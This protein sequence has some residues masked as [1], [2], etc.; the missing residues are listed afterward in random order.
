MA[1][2]DKKTPV[3][4][5]EPSSSEM[6][7]RFKA[8]PA[9]FIGTIIVLVLVVV[10]FVL[11]PALVPESRRG[12]GDL[13]FGY[14][15]KVP[16]SWV[17]G[18][19]F[20]QYQERIARYYQSTMDP[21]QLQYAG[22]NIWRQAFEGA[23]IHTAILQE[24][25]KSNYSVPVK[26]VD[27]QV[28]QLPQ[29]QEKGRFSPALYQR[30][31]SNA[32]LALWRQ[33]QDEL[34]K[35]LYLNDTI[36]LLQSTEEAKFIGN[37]ASKMRTFDMVSFQVDSYPDSEYLAYAVEHP[38]L[39]RSIHLS[40]IS[41]NSSEK[42]AGSILD[43]IKDGTS[44]F[45][46]AAR[47]QSQDGYADRGGNM[48]IRYVFELEEEITDPQDRE[49]IIS[50]GREE[51]SGVIRIGERWAFFR[52]EDELKSADFEDETVMERIRSYMRNYQ[53]GRMEDWAV[54]E[55][56]DFIIDVNAA[57]FDSALERLGK[58]KSSF[59]PIPI[60]Y[61]N[62]DLFNSLEGSDVPDL[63][64]QELSDLSRNENFWKTAFYTQV[65]TPSEPLVQGGKVL[66]LFPTEEI[67]TEETSIE[68]IASTYSSYWLDYMREQ[69][70]QPYFLNS[71][72]M[73]NR[74]FDTYFRFFNPMDF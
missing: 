66:I 73:D 9:V 59:G 6:L 54:K 71:P 4:E 29:F 25:K 67:E 17:P 56:R 16:I 7:R 38:D 61:G 32:R 26:T 23:A 24:M 53:R 20:A 34:I 57:D 74:F 27:K 19:Y 12:G 44:T 3:R 2:K 63:S 15:D 58:N 14:Y 21:S 11:V 39:F 45:E 72:K 30:M 1:Q 22:A 35:A 47:A 41:V 46:D 18:N 65:N 55:A 64:R 48:G 68:G 28:A 40:M 8:N 10:S 49:K 36:G 31:P 50:L 37:M 51:L 62:I 42:E 70:L 13:T 60:N 33:V 52:V 5:K 69:S 43:S